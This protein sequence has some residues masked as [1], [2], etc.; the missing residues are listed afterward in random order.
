MSLRNL[1]KAHK[2]EAGD[3]WSN[4]REDTITTNRFWHRSFQDRRCLAP[5]TSFC[6]PNGDVKPATWHW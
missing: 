4:V 5:A 2:S 6:E 1:L 3:G